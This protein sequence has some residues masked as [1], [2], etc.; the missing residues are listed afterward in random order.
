[1]NDCLSQEL[2]VGDYVAGLYSENATPAIFQILSFTAKKCRLVPA[3]DIGLGDDPKLKFGRD[4]I[5][6]EPDTVN[7]I[8]NQK[9]LDALLRE[10]KVGDY[11]FGS[12]GDYIDPVIFEIVG[13]RPTIAEVKPAYTAG[14]WFVHGSFRYTKDLIKMDPKLVTIHILKKRNDNE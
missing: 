11:A 6:L 2:A 7:E 5:K 12:G 14:H 8:I 4:L 13:F 3:S 10:L 1:M 9:P